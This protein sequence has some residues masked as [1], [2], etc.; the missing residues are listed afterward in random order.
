MPTIQEYGKLSTT[1]ILTFKL[2]DGVPV[3]NFTEITCFANNGCLFASSNFGPL[4]V[5][6]GSLFKTGFEVTQRFAIHVT[7]APQSNIQSIICPFN[8]LLNQYDFE[9]VGSIISSILVVFSAP[10]TVDAFFSFLDFGNLE[11]NGSR[12]DT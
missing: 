2:T 10:M 6:N 8:L 7:V 3:T 9:N 4:Y 1:I 12:L 11:Q 5:D